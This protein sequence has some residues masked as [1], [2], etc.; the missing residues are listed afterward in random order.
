MEKYTKLCRLLWVLDFVQ[1]TSYTQGLSNSYFIES[2]SVYFKNFVIDSRDSMLV[3]KSI[4]NFLDKITDSSGN[5]WSFFIS[6]FFLEHF[7]SRGGRGRAFCGQTYF[8]ISWKKNNKLFLCLAAMSPRLSAR[9][10]WRKR[11]SARPW[12][13][14]SLQSHFSIFIGKLKLKNVQIETSETYFQVMST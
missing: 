1:Q 7:F 8:E 14:S 11:M 2:I 5:L 10:P 6:Q 4:L 12:P 3:L 9:E 13:V